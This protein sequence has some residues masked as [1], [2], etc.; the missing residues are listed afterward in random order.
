MAVIYDL[1]KIHGKE[2]YPWGAELIVESQE[3]DGSW[4]DR[5]QGPVDTCFALLFLRH[6][7]VAKDLTEK[8]QKLEAPEP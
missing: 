6:V 3:S 8:L 5:Y 4:K 1:H 2:W 7:N